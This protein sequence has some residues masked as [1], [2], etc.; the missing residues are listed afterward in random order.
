LK[1]V[2]LQLPSTALDK[3]NVMIPGWRETEIEQTRV[4]DL[5]A[6]LPSDVRTAVDI[7][8]RDG[9]ISSR[10]ADRGVKVTALDLQKPQI[11]DARIDCV[12]GDATSLSFGADHFDLVFCA[13]VLEHIPSSLLVK[14][15]SELARVS[16]RHL[17]IGVPYKQDLRLDRSTCSSCGNTNPPWGHVNS[18]DEARLERLFPT[19]RVASKSFVGETRQAT[20]AVSSTLMEWAGNPYGTYCQDEPCIHCDAAMTAPTTRTLVSRVLAKG[21]VLAAKAQAPFVATRP[22]WIHVLLEK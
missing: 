15:C 7:G 19:C 21:A 17:L 18:F 1:R 4:A 3:D 2:F 16:R 20:N 8:A 9:F 13:E 10:L 5:M 22:K 6:M 14:A 12:K 11:D